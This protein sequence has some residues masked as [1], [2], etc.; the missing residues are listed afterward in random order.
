VF[1][2]KSVLKA[3]R[4]MMSIPRGWLE[5]LKPMML[6]HYGIVWKVCFADDVGFEAIRWRSQVKRMEMG[7][8]CDNLS[9]NV[10]EYRYV[11]Y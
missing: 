10:Q 5:S 3:K 4:P 2:E 1:C 8:D 9:G 11:M 7:Q 6:G